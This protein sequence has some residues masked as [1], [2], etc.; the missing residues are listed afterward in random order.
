MANL[1]RKRCT[2]APPNASEYREAIT[3]VLCA[4]RGIGF[5]P[6]QLSSSLLLYTQKVSFRT[7]WFWHSPSQLKKKKTKFL[8]RRCGHSLNSSL[9]FILFYYKSSVQWNKNTQNNHFLSNHKFYS[10]IPFQSKISNV[11]TEC[12]Q[13]VI[14][15]CKQPC[16]TTWIE[17]RNHRVWKWPRLPANS[18]TEVGMGTLASVKFSLASSLPCSVVRLI[19]QKWV[20]NLTLGAQQWIV[21][22][23]Q[24]HVRWLEISKAPFLLCIHFFFFLN[25]PWKRRGTMVQKEGSQSNDSFL[26]IVEVHTEIAV[27]QGL[28]LLAEGSIT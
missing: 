2:L 21:W 23:V 8:S 19:L 17:Q 18:W 14:F 22:Q 3:A 15:L 27:K 9:C 25:Q 5:I 7:I 10:V 1:N 6:H 20:N 4:L 11:R 28:T 12:P 26:M 24:S 16:R 13:H